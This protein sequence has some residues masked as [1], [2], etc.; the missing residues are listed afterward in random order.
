[1]GM[2]Q[3]ALIASQ[4]ADLGLGAFFRTQDVAPLGLDSL[5]LGQLVEDGV[6]E[7]I[8]RGLYRLAEWPVTEDHSIAAVCARVPDAVVCL[9]TALRVHDI[10]TQ[11]PHE[12]WIAID[13]KARPPRF[14]EV[15]TRVVRF[16]A[17]Q[18]QYGVDEV[19]LEGVPTRITS[20]ARTVADCFH[21]WKLRLIGKDVALEALRD[22]IKKRKATPAEIL[23]A[24]EMCGTK[25]ASSIE[26]YLEAI[27]G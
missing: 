14:P 18:L 2:T 12:V 22:A 19:R 3:R 23:R 8:S 6:I 27:F 11:L 15:P 16:N 20:P 7:R 21:P 25:A 17:A 9:L 4:L 24:E 10:G 1:M 13:R 26:P 5:D